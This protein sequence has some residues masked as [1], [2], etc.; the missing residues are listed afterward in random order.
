LISFLLST[1]SGIG[2]EIEGNVARKANV[3]L[4]IVRLHLARQRRAAPFL[5]SAW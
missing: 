5:L 2:V 4:R 3:G 1:P